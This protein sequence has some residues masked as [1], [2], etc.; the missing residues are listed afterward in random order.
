MEAV[1]HQRMF[2]SSMQGPEAQQITVERWTLPANSDTVKRERL[3]ERRQEFPRF[4]AR[5]TGKDY[6]YLY[7]VGADPAA[8]TSAQPLLRH[9]LTTGS[10]RE[11]HYGASKVTGEVIFVPRKEQ[12]AEDDGWLLSFVYDTS[13]DTAEVVILNA[14]DVDGEPQAVI[15]LPVRV[16]MGF[17]CN[18]I[19]LPL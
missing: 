1:V 8:P 7:T 4:D 17:H 19:D 16:P 18:W 11:H 13:T 6:R 14:D 2:D 3:A 9:D 10:C 15:H 12:G 5:L